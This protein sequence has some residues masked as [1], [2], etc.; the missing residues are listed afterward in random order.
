MTLQ[1]WHVET[2]RDDFNAQGNPRENQRFGRPKGQPWPGSREDRRGQLKLPLD[3]RRGRMISCI[4]V[5]RL[6]GLLL[7][8]GRGILKEVWI[9][10][11]EHFQVK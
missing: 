5:I 1:P 2:S 7:A 9:N 6:D 10:R 8:L 3:E 4:C 11:N